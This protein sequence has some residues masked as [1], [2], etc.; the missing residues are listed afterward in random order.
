VQRIVQQIRAHRPRVRI[1]LRAA[2][3]SREAIMFGLV[4]NAR[5]NRAL[6]KD[7]TGSGSSASG[8]AS[9]RGRSRT[10]PWDP[11]HAASS[12]GEHYVPGPPVLQIP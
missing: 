8:P 12:S 9:R 11:H 3:A 1:I 7:C 4:K 10:S 5:L 2:S 6:G